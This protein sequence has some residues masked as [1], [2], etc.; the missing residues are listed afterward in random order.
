[1]VVSVQKYTYGSVP[2][3]LDVSDKA[4]PPPL[5]FDDVTGF[6]SLPE[7]SPTVF[8]AVLLGFAL[9]CGPDWLLAPLG[10]ESGI[11]PGRQSALAVGRLLNAT[12]DFVVDGE[13]G[14]ASEPDLPVAAANAVAYLAAGLVAY[15][16]LL[17][18]FDDRGFVSALAACAGIAGAV[19]EIGRPKRLTRDQALQKESLRQSFDAFATTRLEP[20]VQGSVHKSEIVSAFRRSVARYRS[21]SA[22]GVSDRV[23][24][25][26]VRHWFR[27]RAGI[28]VT[29]AGFYRGCVLTPEPDIF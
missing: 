13:A 20:A 28:S 3:Q 23:I 14:Y 16:G 18:T 15:R 11:Q 25:Q 21:A 29:P 22:S 4:A 27:T 12:S 7:W 19:Y 10:L 1:V 9:Y 8:S 6:E 5:S 2:S 17:A 26:T 24:E